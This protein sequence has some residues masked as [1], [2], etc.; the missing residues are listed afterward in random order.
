MSEKLAK[1]AAG[2]RNSS[3]DPAQTAPPAPSTRE[4]ASLERRALRLS[5]SADLLDAF[6]Q[7]ARSPRAWARAVADT[8]S[9]L[10]KREVKIPRGLR[11]TFGRVPDLELPVPG[12]EFFTIRLLRCRTVWVKKDDKKGFEKLEICLAFQ[13]VPHPIRGG[14]IA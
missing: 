1:G 14:P 4:L 8:A 5:E 13:I 6:S 11:V 12:Y 9:Y 7:A 3:V 10:H 2:T